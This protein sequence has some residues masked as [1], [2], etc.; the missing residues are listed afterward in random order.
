MGKDL[1]GRTAI[2]WGARHGF[3]G[4]VYELLHASVDM[5]ARDD[6]GMTVIDHAKDKMDLW[7]TLVAAENRNNSLLDAAK[8][9]DVHSASRL[10]DEGAHVN[11]A[12]EKGWPSL[13][14]AA[15]H[16]SQGSVQLARL[17]VENG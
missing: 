3:S 1:E 5:H 13:R 9:N 8:C 2:M 11:A 7:R 14:Y 10:I 6:A 17:L 15:M 16:A 4:A 12:D